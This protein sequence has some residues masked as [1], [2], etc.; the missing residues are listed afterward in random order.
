MDGDFETLHYH[1]RVDM[2]FCPNASNTGVV[3]DWKNNHLAGYCRMS[4][5]CFSHGKT[6]SSLMLLARKGLWKLLRCSCSLALF[7][8]KHSMG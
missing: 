6:F 5:H 1:L 3:F 7:I 8:T 2:T 4:D